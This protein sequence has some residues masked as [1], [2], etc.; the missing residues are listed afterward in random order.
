M[1]RRL[2]P[3]PVGSM[4]VSDMTFAG[5]R[6]STRRGGMMTEL[7]TG[8]I[9]LERRA[10]AAENARA[11]FLRPTRTVPPALPA[12][13]LSALDEAAAVAAELEA[14]RLSVHFSEGPDS[15]VRAQI[16]DAEGNVIRLLPIGEAL[17]LLSAPDAASAGSPDPEPS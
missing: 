17:R 2:N 16:M 1:E 7:S 5:N 9:T 10:D 15:R 11:A 12:A 8:A 13:L 3:V 4:T 14:R 6:D